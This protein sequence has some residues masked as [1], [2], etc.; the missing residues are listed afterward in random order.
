LVEAKCPNPLPLL[1]NKHVV[2]LKLEHFPVI[3]QFTWR[4]T[5]GSGYAQV[6]NN[7]EVDLFG[8]VSGTPYIH[9]IGVMFRKWEEQPDWTEEQMQQFISGGVEATQLL[10]T[11]TYLSKLNLNPQLLSFE[12]PAYNRSH[13]FCW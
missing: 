6:K 9:R 8:K 2:V 11:L 4:A 13:N 12:S 3:P 5:T 7:S 1:D 10:S